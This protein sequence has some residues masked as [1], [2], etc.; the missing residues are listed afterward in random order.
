MT[1]LDFPKGEADGAVMLK[2]AHTFQQ[3]RFEQ[4]E[5]CIHLRQG[6]Q[7]IA[8]VRSVRPPHVLQREVQVLELAERQI[9]ER[10]TRRLV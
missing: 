9:E 10:G 5:L 2:A 6:E 1:V 4:V 7:A 8:K 3:H